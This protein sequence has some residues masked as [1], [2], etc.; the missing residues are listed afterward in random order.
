MWE[1]YNTKLPTHEKKFYFAAVKPPEAVSL[2][3]VFCTIRSE[4]KDQDY[5]KTEMFLCH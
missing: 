4:H 2:L 5:G 1:E 3:V